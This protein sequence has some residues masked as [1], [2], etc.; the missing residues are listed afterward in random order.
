[1]KEN[2]LNSVEI[3]CIV[4]WLCSVQTASIDAGW[5]PKFGK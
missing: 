3:K 1:M 5:C 4:N 2:K